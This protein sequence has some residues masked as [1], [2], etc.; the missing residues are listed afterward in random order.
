MPSIE[1]CR[2]CDNIQ[3]LSVNIAQNEKMIKQA[4]NDIKVEQV[5]LDDFNWDECDNLIQM[6]DFEDVHC[7]AEKRN[8]SNFEEFSPDSKQEQKNKKYTLVMWNDEKAL[9]FINLYKSATALW[10]PNDE[11]YF[12]KYERNSRWEEIAD[13]MQADVE[14]CKRK[15][16]SLMAS[17]RREKCRI[18]NTQAR[19]KTYTSRWFAYDALQFLS[20][21]RNKQMISETGDDSTAD[22][23]DTESIGHETPQ[24]TSP[25]PHPPQVKKLKIKE[26]ETTDETNPAASQP[27]FLPAKIENSQRAHNDPLTHSPRSTKS[28][29][30]STEGNKTVSSLPNS[31]STKTKRKKRKS[32]TS[33][34]SPRPPDDE[35]KYFLD[36][37]GVKMKK[38]PSSI[39]N[40][41]QQAILNIIFKA[42]QDLANHRQDLAHRPTPKASTSYKSHSKSPSPAPSLTNESHSPDPSCESEDSVTSDNSE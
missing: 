30:Q 4:E 5:L 38:Y 16:I 2:R 20:A 33:E 41:T 22:I 8:T 3:N 32:T 10:N 42:D 13:V 14:L 29:I 24:H 27:K 37:I 15:M 34:K 17:Y 19:G 18:R 39:K 26:I 25:P 21:R 31:K 12:R 28:N 9:Q 36:F 40:S 7:R 23:T 6:N 1:Q 35:I 11:N